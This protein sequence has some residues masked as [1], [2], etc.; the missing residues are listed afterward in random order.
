MEIK[1]IESNL[2]MKNFYFSKCCFEGRKEISN[3]AY[4]AYIKKRITK[5]AEHEYDVEVNLKISKNDFELLVVANAEFLYEAEN[6]NQEEILIHK[7]TVAIMFP[8]IRSQ[9]SLMTA[10]PG[11]MPVVL[12]PINTAKFNSST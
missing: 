10:Q 5:K 6:Y 11:M 12:P 3:G 9:V 1:K 4:H 2:K 7:N 8:F